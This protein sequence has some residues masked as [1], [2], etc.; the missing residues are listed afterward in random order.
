MQGTKRP[1]TGLCFLKLYL[2]DI[3]GKIIGMGRMLFKVEHCFAIRNRGVVMLPG[4][5]PQGN[6][7]VRVGDSL[8]L[9]RPDGTAVRTSIAGLEFTN[10]MP[11]NHALAVVLPT[12]LTKDDVPVGTEVWSISK[13]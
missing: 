2:R 12:Q 4:I 13:V 3:A 6:E 9:R 1:V 7:R 10:P 5:V 8:Q 11:A